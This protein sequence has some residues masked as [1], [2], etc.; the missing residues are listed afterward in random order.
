MSAAGRVREILTERIHKSRETEYSQY[1]AIFCLMIKPLRRRR[2]LFASVFFESGQLHRRD[3]FTDLRNASGY[4]LSEEQSDSLC[5]LFIY[6][7]YVRYNS[8][9]YNC[10]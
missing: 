8:N 1:Y 4:L 6:I 7:I 5:D 9:M 3:M 2:R 10:I